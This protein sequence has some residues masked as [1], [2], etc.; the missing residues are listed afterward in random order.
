MLINEITG[1]KTQIVSF[2]SI[3]KV[4]LGYSQSKQRYKFS[5]EKLRL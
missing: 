4:Y 5:M 2:N 1:M 3:L